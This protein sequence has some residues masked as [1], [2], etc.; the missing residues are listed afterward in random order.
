MQTDV[1]A[2]YLIGAEYFKHPRTQYGEND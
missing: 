1:L 2:S